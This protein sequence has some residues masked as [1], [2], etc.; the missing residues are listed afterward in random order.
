MFVLSFAMLSAC[1]DGGSNGV[2]RLRLLNVSADYNSLDLYTAD[3]D[4][5]ADTLSLSAVTYG[6]VSDY[7]SL[8]AGTY[9]LKVKRNGL[10][11]TL[12]TLSGANLAEDSDRTYVSYGSTGHFG[13]MQIGEDNDAPDNGYTKVQ[14]FNASEA[15]GLDVYVTDSS[16]DLED[17]SPTFSGLASG[18][19]SSMNTIERGTY[20]L[21]VTGTGDTADLRLD[22]PQIELVNKGVLAIIFTATQGGVL[23]SAVTLP[24]GGS[25]VT[26][27]NTKVRLRGAVGIANGIR[28]TARVG[29]VNVLSSAAVGVLGNYVQIEAGSASVALNVDGAA[30]PADNVALVAGGEYTLLMWTNA[31]GTQTTLIDDNNRLPESGHAKIRVMNGISALGVPIT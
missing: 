3:K 4:A 17:A 25:P 15:G 11:S 8:T 16:V 1:D 20:R 7:V 13:V 10:S 6:S 19:A 29:G 18:A 27:S 21:R 30:V 23:V 2:A 14:V 22:I 24:Q 5:D 28:A 31:N 26:Y 9:T 12:Q